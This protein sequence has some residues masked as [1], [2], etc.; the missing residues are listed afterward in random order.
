MIFIEAKSQGDINILI[1]YLDN[2]SQPATS[3]DMAHPWAK[4][5]TTIGSISTMYL[6]ILFMKDI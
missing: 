1:K 6:C 5:P 3:I 4:S 2:D